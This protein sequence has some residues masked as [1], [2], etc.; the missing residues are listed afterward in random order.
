[1]EFF[2]QFGWGMMD[3]CRSLINEWGCGSV[4]LS[5][6]DLNPTQIATLARDLR[7]IGGTVLV[8]P[9]FYLP[10]TDHHR[11]CSHSYW[12]DNYETGLFWTG[13]ALN[14]LLYNIS[15][16]NR[17]L[18]C[19]DV[20]LPGLH[21]AVID[22][23]W[24]TQQ[25][26]IVQEAHC[27][28][29]DRSRLLATVALSGDAVRSS[30]QV[31]LLLEESKNWD[32]GGVYLICEHPQGRYLVDDAI[33]LA[34]VLDL[35]AGFR[36][37]QRRVIVGYC[38][39]QMLIAACASATAIA[40]GTWMNVRSFPPDKFR[41][42]YEDEIKQSAVWYYCPQAL[43][44]FKITFLEFAAQRG[45]LSDMAP[46]P[47]LGSS[48]ANPLF[49][50]VQPTSAG[51]GHQAAF[52]HYLQC[53]RTQVMNAQKDTF[54]QTVTEH[55]QM[56]DSAHALLTGLHAVEVRGQLR[57]FEDVLDANRAA[58]GLLEETRGP[59]LRRRWSAL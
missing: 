11:L 17:D 27:M 56:L 52:R 30:D 6:R 33:W 15:I 24:L 8:D 59:V 12:P 1:M 9:Q 22:D 40:S 32:I 50:G 57:D 18:G 10:H 42:Q 26:A 44:E 7:A 39:H 38:N 41:T 51:F 14:Q 31:H 58:L 47:N 4:I 29:V 28:N 46:P 55:R 23:L 5:P 19:N 16:L 54:D 35:I 21:A 45:I 37:R 53:L 2:L 36:L 34:N 3:H 25:R 48:Y 49:S 13:P 43:S 20:I